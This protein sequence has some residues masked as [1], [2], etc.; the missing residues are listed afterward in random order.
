[1][2]RDRFRSNKHPHSGSNAGN[3]SDTIDA[4]IVHQAHADF[5]SEA[6]RAVA[7][8]GLEAWFEG[9]DVATR[10]CARVFKRLQN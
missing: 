8:L 7:Y 4:A 1:M 6:P 3:E 2:S 5:G 9:N 10:R